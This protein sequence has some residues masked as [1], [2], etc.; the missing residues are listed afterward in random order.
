[1]V[2]SILAVG[3]I[4]IGF[5]LFAGFSDSPVLEWLPALFGG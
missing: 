2:Q 5:Y 4:L 1:M 3:F